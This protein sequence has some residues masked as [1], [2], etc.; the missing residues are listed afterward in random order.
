[1]IDE[2]EEMETTEAAGQDYV[3]KIEVNYCSLCREYLTRS[4]ND[5]K[6]ITEHCKTKKHLK[7]YNQSKK[8]EDNA[9]PVAEAAE[10]SGNATSSDKSVKKEEKDAQSIDEEEASGSKSEPYNDDNSTKFPR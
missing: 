10:G 1:M 6:I 7:W 4:S 2:D 8:K 3:N 9:K 5:A